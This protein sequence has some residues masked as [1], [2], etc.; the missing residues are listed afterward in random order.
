[1]QDAFFPA[2]I[3]IWREKSIAYCENKQTINWAKGQG[4]VFSQAHQLLNSFAAI[5]TP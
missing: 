1:M 2:H 5:I 4:P 3:K